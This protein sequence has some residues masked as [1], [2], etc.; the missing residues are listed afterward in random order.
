VKSAPKRK[1]WIPSQIL[2]RTSTL[3]LA[4]APYMT[5]TKI[6]NLL[7]CETEKRR[8]ISKVRS[9]PYVAVV[10]ITNA[11]NL[12]CPYC[13][14][15]ERRDSGRHRG[16]IHVSKVRNLI[17]E[18]GK[19]IIS[20]NLFNWGEPLLHPQI[21]PIVSMFHEARIFTMISTNLNINN[22]ELIRELCEA[23]LDYMVVSLSGASQEI[24]EQYHRKG[25]LDLVLQNTRDLID[26]KRKKG[27]TKPIIEWKYLVFKHNRHEVETARQMAE[28]M[29]VDIF[30]DVRGGGPDESRVDAG[31]APERKVRTKFCHQLWHMVVINSDGGISPC[32]YVFFKNDDFAEYPGKGILDIRNN[33]RFV[34]ARRLFNAS[35]LDGLPQDLQHPCLKCSLVHG[36]P[37]LRSFLASN[38]YAKKAHRT[39]GP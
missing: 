35:S 12:R 13:P 30:R 7:R 5:F 15:G 22:Q 1:K 18:V 36:Q 14:T 17:N 11:C 19:Y 23:G 20:A 34:T 32:C 16:M 4:A 2:R 3:A 8:R 9:R 21:A 25:N 24:Y 10:D 39:G 31:Q 28:A 27:L 6:F 33:W 26:Y 29:G 38:P 37:H